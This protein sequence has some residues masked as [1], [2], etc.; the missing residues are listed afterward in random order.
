VEGWLGKYE[1]H[2]LVDA[3]KY[4]S[5][6]FP[7]A[8][9]SRTGIYGGSYGGFMTLYALSNAPQYFD[10]GAALRAVTDWKNYYYYNPQYTEPRLGTPK[11]DSAQYVR[12][13]PITYADSLSRPVLLLQGLRDANVGFKDMVEY[14]HR[15]IKSNNKHFHMM[16]YPTEPHGFIH[17]WD[18][19]DE[20]R[21]IFKF[22][23]HYLK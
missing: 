10:A 4:L 22:F 7:Q 16:M 23:N 9:T 21:R 11:A 15:L 14:V 20:Y 3:V 5:A 17:P 6:H 1:T 12:S 13:S 2:D 8:D 19:Y 18:W